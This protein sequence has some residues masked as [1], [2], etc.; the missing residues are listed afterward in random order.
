MLKVYVS[1]SFSAAARIRQQAETLESFG[2]IKV[3]SRWYDP[4]FF[5]EK[6]W[7]SNFGGDVASVMARVDLLQVLEADL[8]IIDTFTKSSTGGLF[9]ELGAALVRSL[10]RKCKVVHIGPYNNI[11]EQLAD[12][13][14]DSWDE[15][16]ANLDWR[17]K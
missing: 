12:E 16:Y 6:A 17:R 9:V 3:L 2:G 5:L 15:F 13:H 7:D 10:E 14:Y 8:V 11:F 4:E 1:G